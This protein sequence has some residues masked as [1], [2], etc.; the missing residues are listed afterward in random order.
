MVLLQNKNGAL[1]LKRGQK[2][3]VAVVGPHAASDKALLGSGDYVSRNDHITGRSLVNLLG[4]VDGVT[5][6]HAD[7]CSWRKDGCKG[8]AGIAAA[9]T[10]AKGADVVIIAVGATNC[11]NIP[12]SARYSKDKANDCEDEGHD[13]FSI[14][15]ESTAQDELVKQV[16]AAAT[17][18]V[19]GVL[20][21]GGQVAMESLVG[22]ADAI[23]DPHHPGQTGAESLVSVLFGDVNPSARLAQTYYLTNY[24]THY[25]PNMTDM[26]LRGGPAMAPGKPAQGGTTYMWYTDSA[27]FPFGHGIAIPRSSTSGRRLHRRR[28]PPQPP[29]PS[30]R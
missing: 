15:L 12:G 4:K 8:T 9:V 27:I 28:Y 20:I 18:N 21:H 5:V 26:R 19:V 3:T 17:G 6:R 16:G 11:N 10:A 14:G 30:T 22:V 13:R 23:I 25:R 2:L 1:P 7:G 29:R 24:T